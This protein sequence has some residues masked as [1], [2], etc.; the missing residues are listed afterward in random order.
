VIETT[1]LGP[2]TPAPGPTLPWGAEPHRRDV[3]PSAA[4][5]LL[6][7]AALIPDER[8]LTAWAAI[9]SR[10]DIPSLDGA[11]LALLPILRKNLAALG[12][13]DELLSLFK[14]VHRYSWARNQ[15]LL[16]P[17]IA[18]VQALER[19]GTPTMLMK[20]AA[21]V[22]DSRLD[23]GMR[24][25]N[26]IDVLVPY[27]QR[28][29]A[30]EVLLGEGLVPVGEV[31]SWY[32]AEYAPRF[33]PSHGFRDERD[34]QLDLHWHVLHASCQPDADE[35]FWAA[36]LPIELLGVRTRALCAADE[37][38]LVI[39]HGLRWNALPTYR[40]VVDAALLCGGGIGEVDYDRLVQ[41]AHKRRVTVALR[42]GLEYLQ[43]VT[44]APV[45][46]ESIR[47]L[48][49]MRPSL[50]ERMEFRVQMI[51]PR[52]RG[53][54]Q[55]QIL[56]HQQYV[57]RELS[58]GEGPTVGRR[59]QLERRRLGIARLR[60]LRK[61]ISGGVP[62]PGRPSS[63][64]AAAIGT[65]VPEQST[66]PIALGEPIELDRAEQARSYVV[67]GLWRPEGKGSWI[68]GREARLSLPLAQAASTSLVLEI[69][70]DG[71]IGPSRPSQRL[72]VSVNGV[73][74]A[75]L[76][77]EPGGISKELVVLPRAALAGRSRL[78]LVFGTPEG[79]SPAELGIADDDR[80]VG[81][82]LRRLLVRGPRGVCVGDQLKFG[83]DAGDEDILLGGW[84]HP[85]PAGRWT[86]GELAQILLQLE[87]ASGLLELEFEAT[88]FLGDPGRRLGVDLIANEHVLT[89][90]TFDDSAVYP[91]T[92]RVP[93]PD[94]AI[95][96]DGELLLSWRIHNPVS[97]AAAGISTDQRLLGLLLRRV[98]VISRTDGL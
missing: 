54:R 77:I 67:Y 13:Q 34:R 98:A 26:D 63:E 55:W 74:V 41:Q 9:R 75:A 85:E 31:P 7:Q 93:V 42:A 12:E 58:L 44:A 94:T 82:L 38:L 61:A 73:D 52:A 66:A 11:T 45:P 5:E 39:L 88:P 17:M 87:R 1:P 89:S 28:R 30:I 6:L 83:E 60:D 84:S 70:A 19:A 20:G 96:P 46:R 47:E 43:D 10:I 81:V 57:R 78:E 64:M 18:V 71:F 36:A 2:A 3:W 29:E 86:D 51:Q 37:L 92:V 91:S 49:S 80:R 97:P 65:G 21:F 14:G 76:R 27:A 32:V 56:Y 53:A 68:A 16:A 35:D 23:A 69:S 25:M 90:V 33:V 15:M 50:L 72:E 59:I 62:G 22:A 8:A 48:R 95:G 4:Q 24:P 40:W 79:A